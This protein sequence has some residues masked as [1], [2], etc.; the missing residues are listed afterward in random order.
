ML[1]YRVIRRRQHIYGVLAPGSGTSLHGAAGRYVLPLLVWL[2]TR[3]YFLS[4]TE[5]QSRCLRESLWRIRIAGRQYRTHYAEAFARYV[6][7]V[8][9]CDV[10]RLYTFDDAVP[11][12]E[13]G[14]GQILGISQATFRAHWR[15]RDRDLFGKYESS[16]RPPARPA[17]SRACA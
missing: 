11:I 5:G 4:T 3:G 8:Y 9:R 16:Q 2:Y 12:G 10:M 15:G 17:S 1:A 13:T 7:C 6:L 14:S